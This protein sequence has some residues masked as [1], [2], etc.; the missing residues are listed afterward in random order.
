MTQ[1]SFIST[2]GGTDVAP[3]AINA[4]M[5]VGAYESLWLKSGATFKKIASR[6]ASAPGSRPSDHIPHEV[7]MEVGTRVIRR[8][9]ESLDAWFDVKI[10][11]EIGYPNKLRD[12]QYPA[13]LFYYQG[14]LDLIASRSVA[15]VG[16]RNPSEEGVARAKKLVRRLLEDSFTVVSGLAQGIDTAAH[17]AAIDEGGKTIAVLGTPIHHAYPAANRDLQAHIAAQHLLIS[18]VPVERYDA[19][20]NVRLNR[21][22]F[23]E[24]N[25]TMSAIS[26]ATIIIEAGNT[27]GT[28]VQAREALRQGRK[29]FILNSC[30]ERDDLSW[31]AKF[32]KAGAIRVRDY[33]D[34]RRK[35][36]EQA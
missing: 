1:T 10:F 14:N 9:R 8:L 24:R 35:L 21:W 7:A 30:F 4:T 6:L 22:F 17:S 15:V 13:E 19:Q 27:S 31:P 32:E 23:P 33:D 36:I 12:A 2:A 28:L 18:Q 16:T 25:K 3:G 11:G 20:P 29:L 26:E 5:E 34:I